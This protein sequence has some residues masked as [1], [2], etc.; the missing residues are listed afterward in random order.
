[1]SFI[2]VDICANFLVYVPTGAQVR[3]Y[4][5]LIKKDTQNDSIRDIYGSVK[6]G[7]PLAQWT[8]ELTF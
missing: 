4:K 6:T 8:A 7:H 2:F 5:I 1:M 3:T